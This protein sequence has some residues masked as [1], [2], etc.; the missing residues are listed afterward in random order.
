MQTLTMPDNRQ[1]AEEERPH[2][3]PDACPASACMQQESREGEKAAFASWATQS[4]FALPGDWTLARNAFGRL[5]LCDSQ[6]AR[7]EEVVPVRAFPLSAPDEGIALVDKSGQELVWITSIGELPEA[8][9]RL[10]EETLASR[11]FLPVITRIV[12]V[13]SFATPSTWE[14]DTDRGRTRLILKSEDD[15]RRLAP[16]GRLLIA[17]G[18][19]ISF[20]IPDWR[21]LDATSRK[22][23]KRFL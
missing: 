4:P 9:R 15:I 22:L 2:A 19:G 3:E 21:T 8:V 7:H 11:E 13:T 18:N 1:A 5:V 10:I 17:D 16:T 6:G 20:L 12:S 14:V 23:L